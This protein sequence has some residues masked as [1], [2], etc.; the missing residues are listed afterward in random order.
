MLPTTN[1][2]SA[3]ESSLPFSASMAK[4]TSGLMFAVVTMVLL[5]LGYWFST[6]AIKRYVS[7]RALRKVNVQEFLV[8]WRYVW[9]FAGLVFILIS[10]SGSLTALGLSAAF[11]GMIL[12]WSLQ[13]PVTGVAAWL[14]VI[15]KRPFRIGDRIIINS[16]IGDVVDISLTHITLNQVGGTVSGEEQSGRGVLVPNATLFSHM[17]FNYAY[18]G[19]HILDE[20]SVLVTYGSNVEK[21]EK[22]LITAATNVAK[23]H[24]IDLKKEPVVRMEFADSGIRLRLRYH[25]LATERQAISSD[26][27]HI[28]LRDFHKNEDV[29]FAYPH[30]QVV[31]EKN[32]LDPAKQAIL[33]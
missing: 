21:A 15:L 1:L 4:L 10:L 33:H 9:L 19:N 8:I 12:G 18:Q 23:K 11:F 14:M 30:L 32:H 7:K 17:I 5:W 20:L 31:V 13:V 24:T 28:V 6:K 25:T 27:A 22:I 29:V 26:I 2:Q 16:I 3:I